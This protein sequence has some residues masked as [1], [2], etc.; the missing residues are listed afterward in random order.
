MPSSGQLCLSANW[1][2][3][4]SISGSADRPRSTRSRIFRRFDNSV[5]AVIPMAVNPPTTMVLLSQGVNPSTSPLKLPADNPSTMDTPMMA[6]LFW[7]TCPEK[8]VFAP[9]MNSIPKTMTYTA[10]TTG[11]GI[12]TSMATNLEKGAIATVNKPRYRPTA[13]L[14][15]PVKPT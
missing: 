11:L 1:Q 2:R 3:K 10:L 12:A 5:N 7:L 15:I 14:A 9:S 8:A 13:L 6:A 4:S